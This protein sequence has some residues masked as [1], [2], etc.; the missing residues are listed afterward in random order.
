MKKL[1]LFCLLASFCF[2]AQ[3]KDA[4]WM[5]IETDSPPDVATGFKIYADVNNILYKSSVALIVQKIVMDTPGNVHDIPNVKE[6]YTSIVFN[7]TRNMISVGHVDMF[8]GDHKLLLN[9]PE[10]SAFFPIPS[11]SSFEQIE[12]LACKKSFV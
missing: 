10:R 9:I 5:L 6:V 12:K 11:N 8:D 3:A 4:N 1:F 7:C 2:V